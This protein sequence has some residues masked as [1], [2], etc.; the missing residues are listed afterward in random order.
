MVKTQRRR[1]TCGR[2]RTRKQSKIRSNAAGESPPSQT[3]QQRKSTRTSNVHKRKSIPIA[4]AR[5]PRQSVPTGKAAAL[6]LRDQEK[7]PLLHQS[8]RTLQILTLNNSTLTPSKRNFN[9][10]LRLAPDQIDAALKQNI[11]LKI[12]VQ[13]RGL[14]IKKLKKLVLERELEHLQRGSTREHDHDSRYQGRDPDRDLVVQVQER[15]RD[16]EMQLEDRE[17]EIMEL[18][19]AQDSAERNDDD[20]IDHN[21]LRHVREL[22]RMRAENEEL[23]RQLEERNQLLIQREDE[24]ETLADH[25]DRLQLEIEDIQRRREAESIE[26]SES[27]AQILE[28]REER[29]AVEDDLNAIRDKLAAATIEL[30]QREDE[31]DLKNREIDDLIQEHDRVVEVVEQEWRGEVE[32]AR[33]QVEELRDV[34]AERENE[35]RELRL[36][37]T[38]LE[39]NTNDLHAKFE[40]TLAHLEQEAEDKDAE[41]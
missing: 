4:R 11:N 22:D 16:I 2:A 20:T 41:L 8:L 23:R 31:L 34:L 38:E 15:E 26:R 5:R 21:A 39:A 19:R 7:V 27:R 17:H 10:K 36:N 37:I 32:E 9:I 30:Q 35:A 13:G 28:E 33:S 24:V 3:R 18:R 12:E 1:Q 29:E 14:E 6:S 25:A 40:A